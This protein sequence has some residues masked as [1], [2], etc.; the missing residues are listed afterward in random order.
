MYDLQREPF[1]VSRYKK[2]SHILGMSFA[3]GGQKLWSHTY[4]LISYLAEKIELSQP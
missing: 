3:P 2:S 4:G 1:P